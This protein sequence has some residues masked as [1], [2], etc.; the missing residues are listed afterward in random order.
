M[1][2]ELI[3]AREHLELPLENIE[4]AADQSVRQANDARKAAEQSLEPELGRLFDWGESKLDLVVSGSMARQEMSQA[5]DFDYLIIAYEVVANP[6]LI[7]A[8][9]RAAESARDR[10][11]ARGPGETGT[12]G[13]L[14]SASDLV[15]LIGLERDTNRSLTNRLVLLEESISLLNVTR[16]RSLVNSI[17]HRYLYDYR[18][19]GDVI[20]E[21]RGVPRFL[22]NDV[23]RYWRTIAV[24]YQAKRW[25]ALGGEGQGV[26]YIKLRSTRKLAFVGTIVSL[27]IPRIR[28]AVVSA[29]LLQQQFEMPPLA[30]LAQLHRHV[31][32]R[33]DEE[34][35]VRRVLETADYFVGNFADDGYREALNSVTELALAPEGS[36][37]SRARERTE[38]LEEDLERLFTSDTVLHTGRQ[39]VESG[40]DPVTLRSLTNRYLLF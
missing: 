30:R 10:I 36:E 40:C 9:R 4:R 22:L 17:L 34:Q 8:F 24:D 31:P 14:V 38:R 5:S 33:S 39:T 16:H 29:D 7:P 27:F 15:D 1:H 26:R 12:F 11:G 28:C 32:R 37:L 25:Q 13:G 2:S 6:E 19:T 21:K 3:A 35:C 18:N 23:I 20:R